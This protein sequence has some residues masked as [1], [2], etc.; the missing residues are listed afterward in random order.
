VAKSLVLWFDSVLSQ[1]SL[2]TDLI[3][4]KIDFHFENPNRGKRQP[5]LLVL[6]LLSRVFIGLEKYKKIYKKIEKIINLVI[7]YYYNNC[8]DSDREFCTSLSFLNYFLL[9]LPGLLHLCQVTGLS[10]TDPMAISLFL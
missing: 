6:F 10:T 5:R 8:S 9:V 2:I 4:L 1:S 7:I 3:T